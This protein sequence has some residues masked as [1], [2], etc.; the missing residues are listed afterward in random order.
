MSDDTILLLLMLCGWIALYLLVWYLKAKHGI[1][2][3]SIE[4]ENG[5]VRVWV[6]GGYR[7]YKIVSGYLVLVSE[8]T[9]CS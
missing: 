2:A 6:P 5:I 8:V 3:L 9:E 1:P 7:D 4:N